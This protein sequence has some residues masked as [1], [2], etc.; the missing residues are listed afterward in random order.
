MTQLCLALGE[1]LAPAYTMQ[2]ARA[3]GERLGNLAADKAEE[4]R[5]GFRA[6]AEAFV[7]AYLQQHGPSSGE[8]ITAAMVQA[9]IRP[10]DKRAFGPVYQVLAGKKLIRC[11]RSDLPRR[12]GHGTTG[13]KLWGA[14]S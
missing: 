4:E 13:G 9:G 7:L 11:L 3:E 1:P 6:A 10:K 12:L 5:A 8:D 2:H 14:T